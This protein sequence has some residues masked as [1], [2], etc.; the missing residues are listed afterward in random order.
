MSRKNNTPSGHVICQ[1]EPGSIAEELELEAG[2][3]LLAI[4]NQEIEDVF[5]RLIEKVAVE[6]EK[7]TLKEKK[8]ESIKVWGENIALGVALG[9]CK[10]SI[11]EVKMLF[12][13][14]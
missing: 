7:I 5:S 9:V 10:V 2:D 4:N 12:E 6:R 3:V 14:N 11:D 1:V 8:L 13:N